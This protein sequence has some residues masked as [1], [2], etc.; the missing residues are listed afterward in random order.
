LSNSPLEEVALAESVALL[1]AAERLRPGK[2]RDELL[3]QA[4][5]S[6]AITEMQRWLHSSR[7]TAAR[8]E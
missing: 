8:R 6:E 1:A 4:L 7:V 5:E 2:K 3:W